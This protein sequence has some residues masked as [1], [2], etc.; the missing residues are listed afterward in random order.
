MNTNLFRYIFGLL[1]IFT[2][3]QAQGLAQEALEDFETHFAK[4]SAEISHLENQLEQDPDDFKT[5]VDLAQLFLKTGG[6]DRAYAL[7]NSVPEDDKNY[8]SALAGVTKILIR[9]HNF[10]S[11]IDLLERKEKRPLHSNLKARAYFLI[12]D[13]STA[14][15]IYSDVLKSHP[16]NANALV[17]LALC[18]H[19]KGNRNLFTKLIEQVVNGHADNS[20]AF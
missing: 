3:I 15:E 10:Q 2:F 9:K 20:W 11:A 8:D 1:V 17:G 7:F 19:T 12:N 13:Y 18:E 4:V 14:E 6:L 16:N 5:T